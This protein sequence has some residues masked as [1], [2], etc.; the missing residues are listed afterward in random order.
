MAVSFAGMLQT[1]VQHCESSCLAAATLSRRVCDVQV[2]DKIPV[3]VHKNPDFRL[4]ED[5]SKPIIMVGPGHWA[6]PLQVSSPSG[7]QHGRDLAGLQWPWAIEFLERQSQHGC[8][9]NY[10]QGLR[11]HEELIVV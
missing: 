9:P 3:Y 7:R 2:G 10:K 8:I 5:A 1:P 4:P 11:L 6:G